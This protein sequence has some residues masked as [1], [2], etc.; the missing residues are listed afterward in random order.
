MR[1]YLV[2][3]A[4]TLAAT[5]LS[6]CSL[7]EPERPNDPD[8][9]P[10]VGIGT[11]LGH[12][13]GLGV[14]PAD[15]AL[16]VATHTGLFR[17]TDAKATRVANRYQDT[18]AFTVTGPGEFLASGHPDLRED[19]PPHLGLIQST[20]AGKTWQ[21]LAL[22]GDADFHILE[23]AGEVLYAYD[24]TSQRLLRTTDR[25]DFEEVLTE[26]L[27]SVAATTSDQAV[28]ATT[29]DAQ[30]MTIDPATGRSRE[31][32]APP[33]LFLDT[34][35]DRGLPLVGI[36]PSGAVRI[37]TDRSGTRWREVGSIEGTPVAFTI[38]DQGWYAA[39]QDG[40]LRSTD[41]GRTWELVLR[42][43]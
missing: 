6:A 33:T 36:G 21:P 34:T 29:A 37:S 13:H 17:V 22:Q 41:D 30:V 1:H 23:P 16:F 31:L 40:V 2:A 4:L 10:D 18:M 14:D 42:D 9:L 24:A 32:D 28:F 26:P 12:I 35:P 5:V 15:G 38:T 19:L 20:D 7:A 3:T 39:T 11:E 25:R 43:G 8:G 27:V